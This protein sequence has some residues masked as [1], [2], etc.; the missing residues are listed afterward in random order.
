MAPDP[1]TMTREQKELVAA[2]IMEKN[3]RIARKDPV[4]FINHYLM[5]FDPRP[6]APK[7]DLDF[8]LYDFQVE[9]VHDMVA[10]IREGH[11][12][13]IEK[14][15]DMGVSWL[16]AAVIFWMWLYDDGFQAL[17]GSRKEDYVDNGTLD[18]LF[19]KLDYFIRTIKDKA[20]LPV[21]Y[22]H[23]KHRTYMKLYNPENEN[24]MKGE[25]SNKNF[26]RGGRY[27]VVFFDEFAFWPDARNSWT[28]AGDATKC[29]LAVTTPPDEPSY[30]KTVRFSGKCKVLTLHW[31]RHPNKGPDWYLYEAGRR[32]EDEVLHEIDISWEYTS[33]GRPYPEADK[34]T[35][36]QFKYDPS[37][38]LYASID[39]GLD[40]IAVGYYQPVRNSHWITMVDAFE[41][42]NK[43]IDYMY[44]F[45]GGEIDP[46]QVYDDKALRFLEHIKWWQKPIVFGDPSG[47]SR[48]VESGISPYAKLEQKEIYVQI[49]TQENDWP[50]RRDAAKKLLVHLRVNDTER[51]RWFYECV[52]MARYPKRDPETS[53]QVTP[54][55]QPVH[56]WTSHHRTELEFF[57]VNYYGEDPEDEKPMAEAPMSSMM[58]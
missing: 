29:R 32:T 19:G 28:A 7:A 12:L 56:D 55:K 57:A 40:A 10:A 16:T 23:K 49:N 34:L 41:I 52:K 51:T 47:K 43:T 11:D 27:K 31:S 48:H 6:T 1:S 8:I 33:T 25:S 5:T 53:Q 15:R 3:R 17:M 58:Y 24:M 50:S 54:V 18:S 36:G 35:F 13:F 2:A 26:S 14:S 30:A 39:L 4:F 42:S 46:E 38:P 22:N 37:L 44:P 45:F 21:G 9:T 20:L